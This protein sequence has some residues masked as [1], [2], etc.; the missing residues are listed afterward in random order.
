MA[1]SRKVAA[2]SGA[3]SLRAVPRYDAA[4]YPG[5]AAIVVAMNNAMA[6]WKTMPGP[7]E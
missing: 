5:V 1:A 7:V 4:K 6:R 3:S 2:P